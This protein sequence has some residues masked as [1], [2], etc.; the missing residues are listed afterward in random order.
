MLSQ[1]AAKTIVAQADRA[2][3]DGSEVVAQ[4]FEAYLSDCLERDAGVE[5][6]HL[7]YS[8]LDLH[9]GDEGA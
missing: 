1:S 5:R 7:D 4:C 8:P 9:M 2:R 6:P 3:A